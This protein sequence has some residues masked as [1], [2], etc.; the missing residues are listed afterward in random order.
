MDMSLD[1]NKLN[2]ELASI[3]KR[4]SDAALTEETKSSIK[5]NTETVSSKFLT[6]GT[7]AGGI[8]SISAPLST[9]ET[10]TKDLVIGTLEN[11]VPDIVL[12]KTV[13]QAAAIQSLTGRTTVG[14]N[15]PFKVIT[16][17]NPE[18][19]KAALT[20]STVNVAMAKIESAL[21]DGT[22]DDF[23]STVNTSVLKDIA[24]D[25]SKVSSSFTS[26]IKK[27][28]GSSDSKTLLQSFV[29]KLSGKAGSVK[30]VEELTA[31]LPVEEITNSLS[32]YRINSELKEWDYGNTPKSYVFEPVSTEEEL[33]IEL[34]NITREVTQVVVNWTESY[35]DE[36]LTSKLIHERWA[37]KEGQDH[38]IPFHYII[39]KDGILQ[40]GVPI[41][42]VSKISQLT[43]KK[44][45]NY[46]IHIAFVGGLNT[47]I[48]DPNK[49]L[50]FSS[51]SFTPEQFKTFDTFC[52]IFYTVYPGGQLLGYNDISRAADA[53]GFS[54]TSYA[55]S[56]FG[57]SSMF[58]D[59]SEEGAFSPLDLINKRI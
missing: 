51:E 35:L 47:N 41:N 28:I 22:I 54:V 33:E 16:T 23:K 55:K 45:S 36:D 56:R 25:L 32:T 52:R 24:K 8:K 38:G 34:R 20:N 6:H 9:G 4:F 31:A 37:T 39:R 40:R 57:K 1:Q 50:S 17:A 26:Q 43:N 13:T 21:K 19:I 15:F 30:L 3:A 44:H 2:T 5:A 11:S 27:A 12:E 42:K 7:S 58:D 14:N 18:G 53:P 10:T 59:P 48:G 29:Q 46:T 49:D